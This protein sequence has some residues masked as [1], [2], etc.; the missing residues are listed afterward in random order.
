MNYVD[1]MYRWLNLQAETDFFSGFTPAAVCRC[2][3]D[4]YPGG[5]DGFCLRWRNTVIATTQIVT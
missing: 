5:V 3:D 1:L 2:I 4:I